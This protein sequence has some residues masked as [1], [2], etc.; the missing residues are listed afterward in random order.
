MENLKEKMIS[1]WTLYMRKASGT[2][3]EKAELPEM[4]K[5]V[6]LRVSSTCQ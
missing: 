3:S 4:G 5:T 2:A 1:F 6:D